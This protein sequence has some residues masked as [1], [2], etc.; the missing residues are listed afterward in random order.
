[1]QVQPAAVL[2]VGAAYLAI[3]ALAMCLPAL[4]ALRVD[5]A[6]VLRTE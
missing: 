1:V 4:K 2:L 6:A 3:V 5:P